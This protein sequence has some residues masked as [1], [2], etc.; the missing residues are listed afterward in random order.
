[1]KVAVVHAEYQQ[2]GGEDVAAAAEA[3]LLEAHGHPVVHYHAHNR[4][5]ARVG[6]VRAAR[7]AIWNRAAYGELRALFRAERPHVAHFHNTW[8]L[9]SPAAYYAA[10]DENIPVV[11]T[12]HNYRLICPNALL[13]RDGHPCEDCVGRRVAWPGVLH[14]CYR[15]SRPASAVAAGM[16][17]LHRARGTWRQ[18]VHVYVALTEFA[19]REFIAGGLPAERIAVK[20][21][22][23]GSGPGTGAHGGG[24]ALFVGRLSPEK[25]LGTL[26]DAWRTLGA[27]RSATLRLRIVGAG[28]LDTLRASSPPGVEW[29]GHLPH[30]QVLALMR[31]AALLVLPSECYEGLPMTLLEA[32]ATGLPVVA[33]AHGAMAEAIDDGVTGLLFTPGDGNALAAMLDRAL[34]SPALLA[35]M[36][37]AAR[38]EFEGHY[39]AEQNYPRLLAIYEAA[40]ERMRAEG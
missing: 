40:A 21:N 17:A 4:D 35:D 24:F 25:G 9:I 27:T 28:P 8:P 19:R 14:A 10:R 18:R 11:Q 7:T 6:R 30:E 31:D 36:G 23:L 2:P 26:L 34:S 16:L 15:G 13:F 20:P 1:M 32:F 5:L 38:R 29:L 22:V 39:S 12:L 37:R 33:S 3:A